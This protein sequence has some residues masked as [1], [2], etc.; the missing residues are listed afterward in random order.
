MPKKLPLQCPSCQ[1]ILKVKSLVCEACETQVVGNYNLP[2]LSTLEE[3]DQTFI[4]EF[5]KCSGSLKDMA[6][7]MAL[8]YPTVRNKLDA[9]IEK[10]SVLQNPH[11]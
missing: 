1:S 8:S 3:E 5:I 10:I 11:S 4:L 9:I 7:K 6:N 2:I